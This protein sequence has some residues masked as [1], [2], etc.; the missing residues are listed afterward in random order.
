MS[1]LDTTY[2]T[3]TCDSCAKSVTFQNPSPDM[4]KILEENPWLK[5]NRLI[6]AASTSQK[7]PFS[8]CSSLCEIKGIESGNHDFKEEPKVVVP[9]GGA[10]AQIAAAAAVAK[11]QELANKALKEGSPIKLT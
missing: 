6:Q 3:I 7:A 9:Q 10:Q 8:Y 11:Q 1:V 4:Q 2:R 5:N